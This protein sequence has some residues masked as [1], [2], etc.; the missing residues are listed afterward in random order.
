M[1]TREAGHGLD[2]GDIRAALPAVEGVRVSPL[3]IAEPLYPPIPSTF[4]DDT[5]AVLDDVGSHLANVESTVL[6]HI[7]DRLA[8]ITET[9]ETAK[10]AVLGS[11]GVR[12]DAVEKA[13]DK[14]RAKVVAN[15][16]R[17]VG[18]MYGY[19]GSVGIHFPGMDAVRYGLASGDYLGSVGMGP[20]STRQGPPSGQIDHT[21]PK[22]GA[23]LLPPSG[24]I[25]PTPFQVPPIPYPNGI[26]PPMPGGVIPPGGTLPPG[27]GGVLPPGPG[28][29]NPPPPPLPPPPLPTGGTVF[30]PTG[31]GW[32]GCQLITFP[33]VFGC[34]TEQQMISDG[35]DFVPVHTSCINMCP[36]VKYNRWLPSCDIWVIDPQPNAYHKLDP[37]YI[38]DGYFPHWDPQSQFYGYLSGN[39]SLGGFQSGVIW[40]RGE[41]VDSESCGPGDSSCCQLQ[42]DNMAF[43]FS[44][45][46]PVDVPPMGYLLPPGD[47]S[48]DDGTRT[49]LVCWIRKKVTSSTSGFSCSEK[50]FLLFSQWKPC[51]DSKYRVWGCRN[52]Q[53]NQ[54]DK[55]FERCPISPPP[56][57]VCPQPAPS[58][59]CGPPFKEVVPPA[60]DPS[61][62][63]CDLIGK[64]M[65][66]L[67]ESKP[68]FSS[69]F[70]MNVDGE[71]QG[72]L[73]K[74]IAKAVTGTSAPIIPTLL[75]RFSKWAEKVIADSSKGFACD[76]GSL[77]AITVVQGMAKFVNLYT[78]IIPE[79]FI[80]TLAIESHTA[81]QSKLIGVSEAN[82]AYLRGTITKE[83]WECYVKAA[84]AY[85]GPAEQLMQAGRA[86]LDPTQLDRLFRRD[87]LQTDE[88]DKL[89][90]EAGVLNDVDKNNIHNLNDQWPTMADTITLM[91]RDVADE[92]T[93]DWST[94]DQIF[95]SKYTGL[96][97][98]WFDANGVPEEMAKQFWRAHWHLPSFTMASEMLQR[99]RPDKD[100]VERPVD[101]DKIRN[102][103]L[104]D[105]WH[106]DWVDYL[107]DISYKTVTR[108]DAVRAYN[109][110]KIDDDQLT[111]RLRDNGY[112]EES[113]TFYTQYYKRVRE[114]QVRKSSGYPTMRS[115]N[116]S[117]ARCE[118]TADQYKQTVAKIAISDDQE[119][120]A[121]EAAELA[122]S[123]YL[124]KKTIAA[125]R[126]PFVL[127]IIDD[128]EAMDRLDIAQIDGECRDELLEIWRLDML[129]R[130]KTIS[131]GA[132]C[133][134]ISRG[135]I[136]ADTYVSALVRVG[137]TLA[138]AS[139]MLLLCG[140]KLSEKQQ[141]AAEALA[142]RMAAQNEKE[143]KE[144]EKARKAAEKER[145]RQA[146]LDACGPPSC[147]KNTPGGKLKPPN[148]VPA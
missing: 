145:E 39:K 36:E 79:Q 11:I 3:G 98:K 72:S 102:L 29:V 26:V 131:A 136:D 49:D 40:V 70:S 111:S 44:S 143:R 82:T 134:M 22:P 33:P 80:D 15:S 139:N 63:I 53:E 9:A 115:L 113:A 146:K 37:I 108:T 4:V 93:I 76:F 12:L 14:I 58:P 132:L 97:K 101:R 50:K 106:P 13:I 89:M 8:P 128:A 83:Q 78:G 135:I 45:W 147:P 5:H 21:P 43:D 23:N 67:D 122:R 137:Y 103:L 148:D 142:R 81:C 35:H 10:S 66:G 57:D 124:R 77:A 121:F 127:G 141:K 133:D 16:V 104:Q 48:L 55:C 118:L 71:E 41:Q 17:G 144:Q 107:M 110:Y 34:E 18:D 99:L 2:N 38:R 28:G 116:N 47:M 119:Q 62:D 130:D 24:E 120:Y 68:A 42:W 51:V 114:I 19:L 123:V 32:D 100:G 64:F 140:A 74:L 112:N 87:Y 138:D 27:P 59:D 117:Y 6:S 31:L 94:S 109:V 88:Y 90:R 61:Q 105:D 95:K 125:I 7:Y 30:P 52:I 73:S 129:R 85:V 60:P 96:I 86:K 54:V 84:G 65:Q 92:Q 126:R 20:D 25:P 69:W 46:L 91:M 56:V 1:P 75:S